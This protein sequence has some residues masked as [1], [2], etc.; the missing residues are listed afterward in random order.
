MSGLSALSEHPSVRRVTPQRI[1]HRTLQYIP[2]G[3]LTDEEH[4]TWPQRTLSNAS[5]SMPSDIFSF[6][7]YI[8]HYFILDMSVRNV[9]RQSRTIK[10]NWPY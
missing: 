3:N 4:N 10:C 9:K 2:V 1:V 8:Y 5:V 7:I 6:K